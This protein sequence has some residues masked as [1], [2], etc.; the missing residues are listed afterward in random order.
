MKSP[1]R[2]EIISFVFTCLCAWIWYTINLI[3][4]HMVIFVVARDFLL[5]NWRTGNLFFPRNLHLLRFPTIYSLPWFPLKWRAYEFFSPRTPAKV[6][7]KL[8]LKTLSQ[9]LWPRGKMPVSR[10]RYSAGMWIFLVLFSYLTAWMRSFW[11]KKL[12]IG[13]PLLGLAKPR[14]CIP[15][16][17]HL[18]LDCTKPPSINLLQY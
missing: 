9:H 13:A 12:K 11:K 10:V 18:A 7:S 8:K 14:P 2:R 4:W 5:R 17:L 6:L 1:K 15:L 3:E 16:Q